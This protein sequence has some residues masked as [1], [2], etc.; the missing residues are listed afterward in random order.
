MDSGIAAPLSDLSPGA[1]EVAL[2]RLGPAR[3]G[4][5]SPWSG[6]FDGR[7]R[8]LTPAADQSR[9]PPP[10]FHE[11]GAVCRGEAR[12]RPISGG[13]TARERP[14]LSRRPGWPVR[15]PRRA[16]HD[17]YIRNAEWPLGGEAW[18]A[19]CAGVHPKQDLEA[20]RSANVSHCAVL[21]ACRVS[22]SIAEAVSQCRARGPHVGP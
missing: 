10:P 13:S 22:R 11:G 20:R 15:R 12:A 18:A 2:G 8:E 5:A 21:P 1:V 6:G 14:G 3:A 19:C 9:P 17:A 7:Q 16:G 4:P